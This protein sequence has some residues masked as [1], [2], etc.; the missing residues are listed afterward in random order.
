MLSKFSEPLPVVDITGQLY[1]SKVPGI[2]TLNYQQATED[3]D[4]L[5]EQLAADEEFSSDELGHRR[6]NY[7]NISFGI[8]MGNGLTIAKD[9]DL[10]THGCFV[11]AIQNSKAIK[12]IVGHTDGKSTRHD[13]YIAKPFLS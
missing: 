6:G 11:Q 10:G 12:R 5:I 4:V 8:S 3:A 2:Q 9:L 1:A 13:D 7:P